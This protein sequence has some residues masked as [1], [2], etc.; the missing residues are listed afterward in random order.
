MCVLFWNESVETFFQV[1]NNNDDGEIFITDENN[2]ETTSNPTYQKVR[3]ILKY[4]ISV[5]YFKFIFA[6]VSLSIRLASASFSFEI[7]FSSCIVSYFICRYGASIMNLNN[8]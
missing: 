5:S 2:E 1:M 6:I 4:H 7:S 3:D 8:T